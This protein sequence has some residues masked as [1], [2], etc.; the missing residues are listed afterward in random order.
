MRFLIIILDGTIKTGAD[1][2][3]SCF[4]NSRLEIT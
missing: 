2:E 3:E 1:L 4:N